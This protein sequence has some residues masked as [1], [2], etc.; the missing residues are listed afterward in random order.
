MADDLN[1]DD[2]QRYLG[3]NPFAANE[4][5]RAREYDDD[6]VAV[7]PRSSRR[8]YDDVPPRQYDDGP[9]RQR[10]TPRQ[11]YDDDDEPPRQRQREDF[12]RPK[13]PSPPRQRQRRQVDLVRSG[14][15]ELSHYDSSNKPPPR[16][17]VG[18]DTAADLMEY[19]ASM[20]D[21]T[22]A[23]A[24]R[25]RETPN[26][27]METRLGS[28]AKPVKEPARTTARPH[29]SYKYH[30]AVSTV[31]EG[32]EYRE[33]FIPDDLVQELKKVIRNPHEHF[34]FDPPVTI[35]S[36][37]DSGTCYVYVKE[38][39]PVSMLL[40]AMALECSYTIEFAPDVAMVPRR[41]SDVSVKHYKSGDHINIGIR[42]Q[43]FG[44]EQIVEEAILQRGLSLVEVMTNV[45]AHMHKVGE[46]SSVAASDPEWL[47]D[48][49]KVMRYVMVGQA[50]AASGPSQQVGHQDN[51]KML[52]VPVES[53]TGK[54]H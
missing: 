37:E 16:H 22:E 49:T 39:I 25:V 13:Q 31:L 54:V 30:N 27:K 52:D 4:T 18:A 21:T 50:P 12:P 34:T 44:I 3:Y 45:K 28:Y 35:W 51:S 1:D 7:K 6:D 47:A 24:I 14:R 8:Q 41:F 40:L 42:I 2:L 53:R 36:T 11:Q 20:G 33:L 46:M 32:A 38:Y 48:M 5:K 17:I 9:P 19:N 43:S 10:Q 29:M 23:P 15:A 26:E